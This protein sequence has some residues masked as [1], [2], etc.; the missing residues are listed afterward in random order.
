MPKHMVDHVTRQPDTNL[1]SFYMSHGFI[2][3]IHFI[4]KSV[5]VRFFFLVLGI[6]IKLNAI[7][8]IRTSIV[9]NSVYA[10]L[11]VVFMFNS[12]LTPLPPVSNVRCRSFF[13]AAQRE[14]HIAAFPIIITF[15]ST[16]SCF[17]Y[18]QI[19]RVSI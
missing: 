2:H 16:N 11:S 8:F 5:H 3:F 17:I 7:I 19:Q 14:W 12:C 1:F 15:V 10:S 13:S 18:F 9:V 4:R 6:V